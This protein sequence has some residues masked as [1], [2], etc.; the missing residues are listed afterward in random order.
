MA[1]PTNPLDVLNPSSPSFFFANPQPAGPPLYDTLKNRQAIA[2]AL[3]ARRMAAPKNIG[4][5]LTYLGES[6]G[7]RNQMNALMQQ[8]AAFKAK[9]I[10]DQKSA[11]P[12]ANPNQALPA[13][14][15][16]R[17]VIPPRV[18]PPPPPASSSQG[19][20]TPD[21]GG[22]ATADATD[23]T[24]AG[25]TNIALAMYPGTAGEV[26]SPN[27]TDTEAGSPPVTSLG[28]GSSDDL[29]LARRNAVG[30]IESGGERNPYAT[31]V[32]TGRGD[33]V[34]GRYGIKGSNIP[35]WTQAA[36]GQSLTPQ[37]FLADKN[38]QDATFDHRMGL[39]ANNYGEEGAGRAWYAGER[40]MNNLGNT[41]R[42][43]RLTVANYG[44]DYLKRLQQQQ[45]G[46]TGSSGSQDSSGPVQVAS[47]D[48][49][50]AFAAA[51]PAEAADNPP[52][53]T[54][55]TPAPDGT[56]QVAQAGPASAMP[57]PSQSAQTGPNWGGPPPDLTAPRQPL[58]PA[59]QTPRTLPDLPYKIQDEPK[60]PDVP[61]ATA[62][63]LWAMKMLQTS[64]DPTTRYAAQQRLNFENG[65]Q[66]LQW[67]RLQEQYKAR[68]EIY[69]QSEE[70]QQTFVRGAT[71]RETEQQ[72]NELALQ[73]EQ[74]KAR[75]QA[76]FGG[77]PEEVIQKQ[78]A[79]S[80]EAA[81]TLPA[82]VVAADNAKKLL[83]EGKLY[84]GAGAEKKLDIAKVLTA[85]GAPENP[86]IP[87]SERLRSLMMAQAAS[88][89]KA[90]IGGRATNYE[91]QQINAVAGGLGLDRDTLVGIINEIQHNDRQVAIAHHRNI[92][93][94]AEAD[95]TGNA[96][97]TL[98]SS[99]L[100]MHIMESLVAQPHL[101]ALLAK[102]NDPEAL[103][104]ARVGFDK[105][106]QTPGLAQYIL[107]KQK[108]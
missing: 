27:P 23:E 26:P 99:M 102:K 31:V 43:G 92:M 2:Y 93:N 49:T 28:D 78:I 48:P 61:P 9:Q 98:Q 22:T 7:Q 80:Q 88:T 73:Q 70:A 85:L 63:Q 54:D 97:R 35:Q 72:K 65:Q 10:A 82:S 19:D 94:Y 83:F 17:A 6:L 30:G 36:L 66:K 108:R 69:K 46:D 57:G 33:F 25:R 101:D 24:D 8:E 74:I 29:T 42:F 4:E 3:A 5:G 37:Q 51:S 59:P 100:P 50:M 84:T 44:Q 75:R 56:T 89:R 68:M 76:L 64:D 15:P 71:A 86:A 67:D 38:A 91:L 58:A 16:P 39:Y 107:D 1:D 90:M 45:G 34:Y 103:A 79:A 47:L 95:P 20:F 81:S 41:D 18:T 21:T 105:S 60:P 11:P 87:D 40:G 14:P 53:P 32:D 12:F 96:Y 106:Y 13:A 104:R 77:V 55:I 62:G 52:I